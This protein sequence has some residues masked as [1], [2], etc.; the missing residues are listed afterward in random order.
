[1]KTK[2]THEEHQRILGEM[3]KLLNETADRK[4]T[5]EEGERFESLAADAK[6]LQERIDREKLV[7]QMEQEG[8]AF[9]PT[10]APDDPEPTGG[11]KAGGFMTVGDFIAAGPQIK[12]FLDEGMPRGGFSLGRVDRYAGKGGH[13]VRLSP[14]QVAE[15]KAVPTIGASVI[16]PTLVP[17]VVRVTERDGISLRDLVGKGT[18]DSNAVKYTRISS[19]TRAAAAVA[20]GSAKPEGTMAFDTITEAVRKIA[21]WMPVQDEQ[22]ADLAGL[23]GMINDELVYDVE[24]TEEELMIYGS[25]VGQEFDGLLTGS[26]IPTFSR[27]VTGDTLIDTIRRMITDVRVAHYNPTGVAVDPY[28]WEQIVLEKGSDARYVWIVVTDGA[29]QRLHGV[30]VVETLAVRAQEGDDPEARNIIVGDWARG[31]KLWTRSAVE[32]SVGWQDQQ[33]IENTRTILA[34]KRSAF[35][36]LRP[37]AFVKFETIAANAS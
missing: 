34:E 24:K 13:L 37:N 11:E 5:T 33:F 26:N 12:R 20:A 3:Q 29:T 15:F 6:G 17:E 4:M 9:T 2:R 35:G 10:P 23:A 32:V 14:K 31:A 25:G 16:D 22:L 1:M 7:Q 30:P 8:K 18:T 36:I 28:D 27:A 21:V 19:V